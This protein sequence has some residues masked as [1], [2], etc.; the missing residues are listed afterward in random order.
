MSQ[1]ALT[2]AAATAAGG[3]GEAVVSVVVSMWKLLFAPQYGHPGTIGPMDDSYELYMNREYYLSE[4][5]S[6][7]GAGRA[8]R[9]TQRQPRRRARRPVAAGGQQR[10]VAAAR[11]L[12]GPA[13]GAQ[14]RR[15][16]PD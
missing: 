7:A 10:P 14:G 5:E 12:Q 9:R 6:A 16:G 4:P 13:A 2:G 3:R 1:V 11:A 8:A 15:H